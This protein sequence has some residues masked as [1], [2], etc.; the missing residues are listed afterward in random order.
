MSI[1]GRPGPWFERAVRRG[2]LAA[3]L[4]EAA[5]LPRPLPHAHALALVVPLGEAGD[6]RH[7]RWAARWAPRFA[8]DRDSVDLTVLGELTALLSLAAT[9]AQTAREA[10]AMLTARHGAAGAEQLLARAQPRG[11]PAP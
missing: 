10:L 6:A 7:A 2:D 4:S 3:A 1:K 8:L 5:E 9:P 11:R